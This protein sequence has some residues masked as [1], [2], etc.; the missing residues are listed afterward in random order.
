MIEDIFRVNTGDG[1]WDAWHLLQRFT[2]TSFLAQQY[3]VVDKLSD[4]LVSEALANK[5]REIK[6]FIR[7]SMEYHKACSV[8][9]IVSKPNL[10]YYGMIN[11]ASAMVLCKE[12][13]N[14][15][16]A[17][18]KRDKYTRH[19]L[20]FNMPQNIL[21]KTSNDPLN[22]LKNLK[23]TINKNGV[24]GSIYKRLSSFPVFVESKFIDK[25]VVKT[26][27]KPSLSTEMPGLDA[28][29][30]KTFS[31][32]ELLAELPTMYRF[33]NA[34]KIKLPATV[35]RVAF[36]YNQTRKY[37]EVELI[38]HSTS[39][40]AQKEKLLEQILYPIRSCGVT[41]EGPCIKFD[42]RDAGPGFL[43]KIKFDINDES[44][45]KVFDCS[46]L[47][48]E[49]DDLIVY[50]KKAFKNDIVNMLLVESAA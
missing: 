29:V 48:S 17:A 23:V 44:P 19:G 26:Q 42:Y 40:L 20:S 6:H 43:V 11:L 4:P 12:G 35:G 16:V 24:F 25:S 27:R 8:V 14:F 22:I 9:S 21:T 32:K 10:L 7:L 15:D 41:N 37:K 49:K 45:V 30:G 38:V 5:K 34:C 2:D 1:F 50:E 47:P 36:S 31:C 33:F 18:L 3:G 39:S 13:L 28:I 46:N